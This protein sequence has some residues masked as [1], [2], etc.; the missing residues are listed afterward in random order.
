MNNTIKKALVRTRIPAQLE[1]IGLDQ[2]DGKR[3]KGAKIVP[4]SMGKRLV[5]DF[6]CSYTYVTSYLNKTKEQASSLRRRCSLPS[7]IQKHAKCSNINSRGIDLI[8]VAVEHQEYGVKKA[9][10]GF[11][12]LGKN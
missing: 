4:W 11:M 9:G 2:D 10:Y 12:P 6:T 8:V 5:W 3:P 1:P 7:H